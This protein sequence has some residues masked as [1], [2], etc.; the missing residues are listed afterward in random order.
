MRKLRDAI[1][2]HY[3]EIERLNQ[4][5]NISQTPSTDAAPHLSSS[6]KPLKFDAISISSKSSPMS[7]VRAS[8]HS[9]GST[10]SI[11]SAQT[12]LGASAAF[13]PSKSVHTPSYPFPF[14]SP[15]TS[16][17]FRQASGDLSSSHSD[18]PRRLAPE[19]TPPEPYS[20][21]PVPD[22]AQLVLDVN[23]E[24]GLDA[25]WHTL[26]DI[27]RD[28]YGA[29][30]AILSLPAD[31][32][33]IENV[34]WAQK[35][36]FDINGANQD[37]PETTSIHVSHTTSS[38][39][40][41]TD[42]EER[43]QSW[44][45]RPQSK[46][47][48]R[49]SLQTRHSFAGYEVDDLKDVQ[50]LKSPS[51]NG[52]EKLPLRYTSSVSSNH[53][54][55][56]VPD[57]DVEQNPSDDFQELQYAVVFQRLR[58][59]NLD[60]EPLMQSNYIN[61]ILARNSVVTLTREFNTDSS[62]AQTSPQAKYGPRRG[63]EPFPRYD[64]EQSYEDYEQPPASPWSQSPAPSPAIQQSERNP[65]FEDVNV[66]DE[67]FTPTPTQVPDYSQPGS[68]EAIGV[69]KA[70][71]I[72]HVPL[73][74]P[75]LSCTIRNPQEGSS[76]QKAPIA[77]LSFLS[78][79][80][81]FPRHL[82]ESISHFSPHLA[83]SF[84]LNSEIE[85]VND[86]YV[87]LLR[88]QGLSMGEAQSQISQK[89]AI[90]FEFHKLIPAEFDDD[91][92][93]GSM[94]T[95]SD[96]SGHGKS[97]VT[98]VVGTPTSE[99]RESKKDQRSYFDSESSPVL[100]SPPHPRSY[101][102]RA[103]TYT[104]SPSKTKTLKIGETKKLSAPAS[105]KF[106]PANQVQ[107]FAESSP[108]DKNAVS[109]LEQKKHSM[110][111]SRGADFGA[112]FQSL[113]ITASHTRSAASAEFKDMPPPSDRLLRT[114]IDSLPVQLFTAVPE[115]G[116]ISWVNSKYLVFRGGL[117][118]QVR[119]EPWSSLHPQDAE[120]YQD[121]WKHSLSSGHQFQYKVRL[122]RFDDVY[123]WFYV[124][125]SPLRDKTG[126]VVHWIGTNVDINDQQ[127][128][129]EEAA[130]AKETAASEAKYR[131]L[132]NLSPQIVFAATR[133]RGITFCNTRWLAYSGQSEEQ[134]MGAGFMEHIHPDD[135]VKCQLPIF[136]GPNMATN[137]PTSGPVR[138]PRRVP[139]GVM[140]RVS[141]P[142][143]PQERSE[144]SGISMSSPVDLPQRQLSEL[145]QKGILR[146]TRDA[147]GTPSYSTEVRLRDSNGVY[148]W[149]LVRVLLS[150]PVSQPEADME[151]WYGSC[152]DINDH[153]ELE[154]QLKETMDAKSRFLS[155][156]SHEIRTPLNGIHGM[157]NFLLD[158]N[159]TEEQ[160]EHVNV[161]IASTQGLRGLINDVLDLSKVE[162]GMIELNM[163]WLHMRS[164]IEEVIDLTAPMSVEKG[165]DLNYTISEAVPSSCKGDRYRI[166]QVLLNMIGNA[167]KFT[168]EGEVLVDCK[169]ASN[170]ETTNQPDGVLVQF[171]IQDT[172][173]GFTDAEAKR[174]FKRFSQID[175]SSTR[176]HGGS[177]LGLVISM[178]LIELHGG[179]VSAHSVPGRG[180]TFEFT[181]KLAV[182]PQE[183][184]LQSRPL[185]TE[186]GS[187]SLRRPSLTLPSFSAIKNR[188]SN[189]NTPMSP[190]SMAASR[191]SNLVVRENGSGDE[192]N[193]SVVGSPAALL[194]VCP[195]I[196]SR[197]AISKHLE[198]ILPRDASSKIMVASDADEAQNMLNLGL[199]YSHI[200]IDMQDTISF[201][202]FINW[203]S[204]SV[205]LPSTSIIVIT[206][207]IQKRKLAVECRTLE[208]LVENHRCQFVYKPLKPSKLGAI[209]DPGKS[210]EM[211]YNHNQNSA[212]KQAVEQKQL[213]ADMT[214]RLGNKDKR[215]LIVEDNAVNQKVT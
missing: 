18:T 66:L 163:E 75:H 71:T 42:S 157:A 153:K 170:H 112:S 114:I 27:L 61:R 50:A 94:A 183:D 116:S 115:V 55:H 14:V 189:M 72:I 58:T 171:T 172:G 81:P 64:A 84:H 68:F 44:D 29:S 124:R 19:I 145:A 203:I 200:I 43:T 174:L 92:T 4:D 85:R 89:L 130:K 150:S 20:D 154:A 196:W 156:M 186:S 118:R 104:A 167:I 185:L 76:Y 22:L 194:I 210:R 141:S 38:Q 103:A 45:T 149:H 5:A 140:S 3:H 67:A 99:M 69:D 127:I 131:A 177:G 37:S 110:L 164:I 187:P 160:L 8:G 36:S 134:A 128:F 102:R 190:S 136:D 151:V 12:V 88:R 180:S 100:Q 182:P 119:E 13:G 113:P 46:L 78:S 106:R 215:V 201:A 97:R 98:S 142:D 117:P 91:E 62:T 48:A 205:S 7:P 52:P 155:N 70:C 179:T 143:T 6:S 28:S 198:T 209:F 169:I 105:T 59:L 47:F 158:S 152:S 120:G 79:S 57:D 111:H 107:T 207:P 15:S 178:Q 90:N 123:R 56:V 193:I 60:P 175:T 41:K 53:Q 165:V 9:S 137:V 2:F 49:P 166:R 24:P 83:T 162:A 77:I 80:V 191:P 31:P 202:A 138:P 65:F 32:T 17:L 10:A 35:A 33:D 11:G 199:N 95:S 23:A 122:K 197:E 96:W 139:S 109:Q 168:T 54:H 25:W 125:A 82:I 144:P 30:K 208:R 146:A 148:R 121:A 101:L 147:D 1:D 213:F 188:S 176:Q 21:P 86:Q 184:T 159:L 87:G 34:P 132:A 204:S 39:V 51:L 129:E 211:S 173:K 181:L 206:D 26:A 126:N 133:P 135:L 74:H 40:S 195:L 212:Q 73:I 93:S 214:E 108:K 161:I 16:K 192:R 63:S